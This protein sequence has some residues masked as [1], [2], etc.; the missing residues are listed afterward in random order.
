MTS[1]T[2]IRWRRSTLPSGAT[3]AYSSNISVMWYFSNWALTSS[4]WST[5][6]HLQNITVS[7]KQ[8]QQEKRLILVHDTAVQEA[9]CKDFLKDQHRIIIDRD[10]TVQK[11]HKMNDSTWLAFIMQDEAITQKILGKFSNELVHGAEG[12]DG[13]VPRYDRS[14]G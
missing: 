7:F 2:A 6:T 3:V 13:V 5:K 14:G 1:T 11:Y 4:T 10:Y 12:G 8:A 9:T